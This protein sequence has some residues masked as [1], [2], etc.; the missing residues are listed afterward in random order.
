MNDVYCF[1]MFLS[2]GDFA[3]EKWL[4]HNTQN[5]LYLLHPHFPQTPSHTHT[6]FKWMEIKP[7]QF[8]LPNSI[9]YI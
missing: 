2:G 7:K 1:L 6:C 3:D 5:K 9:V 8:R 4:M